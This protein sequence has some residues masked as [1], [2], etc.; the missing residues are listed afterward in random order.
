M[1]WNTESGGRRGRE[2]EIRWQS[3]GHVRRMGFWEVV[4]VVVDVRYEKG[5]NLG[6]KRISQPSDFLLGK[7]A[8]S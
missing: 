5:T 6:D 4:V 7:P 1:I 3:N 2:K 8:S